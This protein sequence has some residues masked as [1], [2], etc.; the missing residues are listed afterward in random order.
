MTCSVR[1]Y[2]GVAEFE[3]QLTHCCTV[4][5]SRSGPHRSAKYE[6]KH[7]LLHASVCD[8][9]ELELG[10]H[11]IDLTRLLPLTLEELEEERSSG[12]WTTSFRL[13][14]KAKG[15]TMNVSF[16]YVVIGNNSNKLHSNSSF[17][18]FLS[19]RQ[20][21]AVTEKLLGQYDQ[22][23][24]QSIRRVESLPARL[25][26]LNQP[27]EDIKDLHEV[28]P[29][30]RSELCESVN[31]LHQ[32][33]DEEM[34]RAPDE[35]IVGDDHLPSH[36][37]P[38][39]LYSF[40]SIDVGE[41]ISET[42][43]EISE[44]SVT[45]KWI[46]EF[47]KEQV[48]LQD[49]PPKVAQASWEAPE[50]DSA[51]KIPLSKD[52]AL[53]PLDENI[54]SQSNEQS[55]S[56]CKPKEDE[57][58]ICSKESI[59]KELET[60]LNHALDLVNE[61]L[62]SQDDEGDA[63][64]DEI[65]LDINSHNKDLRNE[66]SLSLDDV[67]DSVASDFLDMLGIE[68]SPFR[69]SSENEAESPRECLLREFEKDALA[70]GGL[71]NFDVNYDPMEF[72][73]DIPMRSACGTISTDFHHSSMGEGSKEMPKIETD[74]F[75]TK[76]RASKLEDLETEALMRDWGLNEKA[77]QH[78]SPNNSCGFHSPVEI[79]SENLQQLPS[80]A[81]GLGPF[82]ETKDGG[83][84]RSMNPVLFQN[85][86]TGGSLIMQVSNPV[87]VPAEMGSTV[88]DI[89]QGLAAVGIEKLSMQANK[90]M[91][92][93][94]ITGKTIQ[95]IA[96][97]AV[98]SLDR[99]E[100]KCLSQPGY[101]IMQNIHSE[102]TSLKG[103]S[104]APKSGKF[105]S[106]LFGTKAEYA[107]LEDLAPLAMDKI[108]GLSVEG[109]RIQ[110]GMSDKDAPLNISTQ[111][112]GEFS[113]LKGKNLDVGGSIILD[114]TS[115]LQLLDIEDNGEDVDGL[116]GLSL[117]LNE[118]MKLDSGEINDD[119]LLNERTSRLLPAQHVTSVCL[120]QRRYKGEKRRGKVRKHSLLGNNFT[121]A[122]MVQL[123]DP[124]R[125]YEPVGNPMLALIQVERVFVPPKTKIYSTVRNSS[126]EEENPKEAGRK[127]H[128][129]IEKPEEDKSHEE[130]PEP[131]AQY[132]ISEVHIAG[133]KTEPGKNKLWGSKKQQQ[134]GSRWL[135]ANGMGK[136]N[137][138]PL[139]KSKIFVK[140]SGS[141]SASS[142]P[143]NM[144]ST[145]V[146]PAGGD[147]LWSVSSHVHGTDLATHIRNPNIISPN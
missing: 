1:V 36:V 12:K 104:S 79:P 147:T 107:C 144:F 78:S 120:A 60:A 43:L 97:E 93:E 100:R 69:L 139:M 95:Q 76:T 13:S 40:R 23:G 127:E 98:S 46:E 115:G 20:N 62:D 131:I 90:L 44:F 109:L 72:I 53:H 26:S 50:T 55:V 49:D 35:N 51:V 73:C 80:L 103:I 21:S 138:H 59:M 30:S 106:T 28:L 129:I 41:K 6:A 31:L 133:L 136:K 105:G 145:T 7:F 48:K 123:H 114:G 56:T 101:E 113:A 14:G 83:F 22:M 92:L 57:N 45:E 29:I 39:I 75:K 88:M 110:S 146:Q 94:D 112:V 54:V 81:E 9:P 5:G 18:E 141:A 87:V 3:E 2:Q 128:G 140:N 34:S 125:N 70:N 126:D 116:M 67:T 16:G 91:P 84:L 64:H 89:L 108:E 137:K 82:V 117:T 122:L 96:W 68:H 25:S 33:L 85:A 4:Y 63:L 65:S 19:F 32:K 47:T 17:P 24:E 143:M 142:S 118:W 99:P 61:G 10:T 27:A 119:D 38:H 15:A 58:Y 8:A 111:S 121:V 134:S 11:H 42:E 52:A 124:M 74:T 86:K 130:E 66:I 77:Y 102:G 135:L 71:L 132:K 37:G